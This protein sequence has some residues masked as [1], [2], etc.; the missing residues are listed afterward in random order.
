MVTYS[1]NHNASYPESARNCFEY[2]GYNMSSMPVHL[3]LFV[4]VLIF[5]LSLSCYIN[6][7]SKM[8]DMMKQLKILVMLSPI[9]ILVVV[10]C[11]SSGFFVIHLPEKE[12]VHR[13]GGSPWGVALLLLFLL[14]M[15][16]YQSSFHHRW[17]PV[18][19]R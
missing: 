16:S 6:F 2:L 3:W 12:S 4:I 17:F 18:L 11:L 9:L 19:T 13:A 8:E 15:V 5:T 10:Q 7:E 1:N 14:L